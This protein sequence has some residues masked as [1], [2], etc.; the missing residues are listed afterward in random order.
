MI[1]EHHM[2]SKTR[3][4]PRFVTAVAMAAL[5]GA[6]SI[7]AY[8]HSAT[9]AFASAPMQGGYIDLV[10][11]VSPAVV[12]IEVVK[13]AT[14]TQAEGRMQGQLPEGFEDFQRRFGLPMPQAPHGGQR[15]ARGAGTGFII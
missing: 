1:K 9:P 15:E 13:E 11:R 2:T 7:S 10:D 8:T 6:G 14:P 5:I 3:K 4:A 12:T